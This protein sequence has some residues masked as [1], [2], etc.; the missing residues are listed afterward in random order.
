MLPY[1]CMIT[2]AIMTCSFFKHFEEA[3]ERSTLESD[4]KFEEV[5]LPLDISYPPQLLWC[6]ISVAYKFD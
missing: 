2:K 6:K 5:F 3:E 1:L 4:K